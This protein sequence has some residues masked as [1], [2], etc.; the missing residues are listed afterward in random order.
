MIDR[1]LPGGFVCVPLQDALLCSA[2]QKAQREYDNGLEQLRLIE[3]LVVERPITEIRESHALE[4]HSLAV[5]G[6]FP[7]GGR[8]RTVTRTVDLEGGGAT[9]VPPEA[10]LVPGL[11]RECLDTINGFLNLS[12][13]SEEDGLRYGGILSAAGYALWRF[14]WIHPFAGG[15]GRTSRALA[16][17]VLC[18]DF[19]GMIPGKPSVPRIIY[20]RCEQYVAALRAADAGAAIPAAIGGR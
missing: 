17:L 5:E 15:N 3:Y 4:L 10:A 18:I 9:H 2:D 11:V 7:C 16:Y 1:V 19:G 14:N 12:R 8:Y 20:D 13:A 6:V